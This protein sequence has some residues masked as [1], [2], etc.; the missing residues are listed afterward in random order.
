MKYGELTFGV[1]TIHHAT[2]QFQLILKAEIDEIGINENTVWRYKSGVVRQK[3]RGCDLRATKYEL[4]CVHCNTGF[5]PMKSHTL[6]EQLFLS[7]L[8]LSFFASAGSP[9]C[10]QAPMRCRPG[11]ERSMALSSQSNVIW[12]Q[13]SFDGRELSCF[14]CLNLDPMNQFNGPLLYSY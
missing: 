6:D 12:V 13:H 4:G 8:L 2:D 14:L 1:Q 3:Q 10:N 5:I 11:Y 7:L 9:F